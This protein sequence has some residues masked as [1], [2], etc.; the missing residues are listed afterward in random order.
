[1]LKNIMR[2]CRPFCIFLFYRLNDVKDFYFS[3]LNYPGLLPFRESALLVSS[4]KD[5]YLYA[6]DFKKLRIRRHKKQIEHHE[7]RN[8]LLIN[9]DP[10]K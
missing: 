2:A 4:L 10:A 3:K 5:A 6:L 9:Y 7:Q 1:M 8:T